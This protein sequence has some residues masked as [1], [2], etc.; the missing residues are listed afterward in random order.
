MNREIKFRAWA[1]SLE[2]KKRKMF[3]PFDLEWFKTGAASP[4]DFNVD[5]GIRCTWPEDSIF[6]QY[7]GIKD[8]NDK[9]IYEGDIIT[10]YAPMAD[11]NWVVSY[12]A[13]RYNAGFVAEE[14]SL[15][16][17]SINIWY[18]GLEIIGNIYENPELL[19][20]ENHGS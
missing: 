15:K 4:D 3:K 12:K 17:S 19:E 9:E 6:L 20:E 13:D 11:K 5:E 7:T 10:G 18:S 8:K 14:L 2:T 1:T 16:L